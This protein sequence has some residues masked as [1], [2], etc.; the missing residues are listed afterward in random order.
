MPESKPMG[1][2][3]RASDEMRQCVAAENWSRAS[4]VAENLAG[5][6]KALFDAYEKE[7]EL[8]ASIQEMTPAESRLRDALWGRLFRFTGKANTQEVRDAV[9]AEVESVLVEYVK[10]EM[11][12][13]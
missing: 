4:E 8:S 5:Y 3:T 13:R 11:G 1:E 6:F 2:F 12:T 10:K 9:Q 7:L